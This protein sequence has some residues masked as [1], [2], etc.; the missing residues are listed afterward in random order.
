MMTG[1]QTEPRPWCPRCGAMMVLHRPGQ[2]DDWAA[3][4]SCRN[5]SDCWGKRQIGSDGKPIYH[6]RR[7]EFGPADF[8]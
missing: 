8:E 4:W 7:E 5:F 1:I 6:E 2:D 3:F